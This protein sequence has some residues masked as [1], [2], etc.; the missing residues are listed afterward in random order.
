MKITHIALGLALAVSTPL[1]ASATTTTTQNLTITTDVSNSC[2]F[3][4]IAGIPET[5]DWQHGA[6][7]ANFA[8][9]LSVECNSGTAY[10]VTADHGQHANVDQN[11]LSD[12][13]THT[14]AYSL[15]LVDSSSASFDPA[16]GSAPS[17]TAN[18]SG[19]SFAVT[20]TIAANQM[21]PAGSY[22]DTVGFTVTY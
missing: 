9:A 5:Y 7:T 22:Q 19:Q 14:L 12:G 6:Y 3:S 15:Q 8:A 10:T 11:E 17:E 2:L 18:G 20:L 4:P 16:G 1:A 21:V 13:A